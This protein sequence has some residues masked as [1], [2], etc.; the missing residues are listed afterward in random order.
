MSET[1]P[2]SSQKR[3]RRIC[4]CACVRKGRC[5][6]ALPYASHARANADRRASQTRMWNARQAACNQ[7]KAAPYMHDRRMQFKQHSISRKPSHARTTAECNSSETE[8]A[9]SQAMHVRPHNAI[10][11]AS[12]HPQ[13][14][15]R[16][17]LTQSHPRIAQLPHKP[18]RPPYH[19]GAAG[20]KR[21]SSEY[22][23]YL[24][25]SDELFNQLS[26]S[27]AARTRRSVSSLP[28]R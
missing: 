20:G 25:G 4:M 13:P 10:Q 22:C 24:S 5:A 14:Q 8:S 12:N 11:S 19:M 27:I 1:C 7:L 6:C 18:N 21:M 16:R 3:A 2:A 15:T 23:I 17:P 26:F 28:S 9:A